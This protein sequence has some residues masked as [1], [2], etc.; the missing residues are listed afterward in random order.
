MNDF[1]ESIEQLNNALLLLNR[2]QA[3]EILDAAGAALS[4]FEITQ[5]IIFPVLENI[6]KLWESGD[7][8]LSQIYMSGKIC[9]E[10][11]DL[12]LPAN[13]STRK[14]QPKLAITTLNDYHQL[15][16][17]IVYSHIRSA[18]Y[19]ITDYGR[20]TV[21]DLISRIK[22]DGTEILLVSTLMLPSALSVKNLKTRLAEISPSTKIMVGGAPF[23]MDN[24]LWLY[25]GADR[26]GENSYNALEYI[27][28]FSA[29]AI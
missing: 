26:M 20:T 4:P 25:V 10:L 5:K 24:E 17:R 18:G 12:I 8:A 11:I 7:V 27:T 22:Q 2:L 14:A 13:D 29:E 21:D 23:S 1:K 28:E 6:G 9:E 15:G 16:K 19:K 3:K